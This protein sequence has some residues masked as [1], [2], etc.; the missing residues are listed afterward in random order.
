MNLEE[1]GYSTKEFEWERS[2][3]VDGASEKELEYDAVVFVVDVL[4]EKDREDF[5]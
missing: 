5:H 2:L 1:S 4:V 3:D